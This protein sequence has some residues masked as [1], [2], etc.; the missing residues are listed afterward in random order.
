M[1]TDEC[2]VVKIPLPMLLAIPGALGRRWPSRPQKGA[3]VSGRKSVLPGDG[4]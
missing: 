3:L 1:Y 2:W 4:S